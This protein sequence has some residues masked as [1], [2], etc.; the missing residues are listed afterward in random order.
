MTFRTTRCTTC[1]R[2]VHIS[3]GDALSCPVCSSPLTGTPSSVEEAAPSTYPTPSPARRDPDRLD[4]EMLGGRER[5]D[6]RVSILYSKHEGRDFLL[7]GRMQLRMVWCAPHPGVP[8]SER[9]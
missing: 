8:R 5:N 4:E 9:P 1:N 6:C 2:R 7:H 3:E